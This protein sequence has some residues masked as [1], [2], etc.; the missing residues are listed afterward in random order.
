MPSEAA[1]RLRRAGIRVTA[2]RMAIL[3]LLESD[4]SHPTAEAVHGM[5][6]RDYPSLSL[7]TVYNTIEAYLRAGVCRRVAAAAGT[8]LRVD[9]TVAD[10][11]HAIC[12]SCGEIF[13]VDRSLYPH[14]RTMPPLPGGLRVR[15]VRLEYDVVCGRCAGAAQK[16][17]VRTGSSPASKNKR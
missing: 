17:S 14:P 6:S 7:S 13:D 16:D 3:R 9:G 15:S 4:R 11:D 5:L 1:L 10:H 12:S 2:P 8:G